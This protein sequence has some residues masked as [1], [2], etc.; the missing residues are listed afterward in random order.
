MDRVLDHESYLSGENCL[1]VS[2]FRLPLHH[3]PHDRSHLEPKHFSESV[4]TIDTRSYTVHCVLADRTVPGHSCICVTLIPASTGRRLLQGL[5]P[6][7]KP[8]CFTAFVYTGMIACSESIH[9]YFQENPSGTNHF[10][11]H[12]FLVWRKARSVQVF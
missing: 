10:D 1:P 8:T 3:A 7:R 12:S 2:H 9:T 11:W 6:H 4:V 5:R